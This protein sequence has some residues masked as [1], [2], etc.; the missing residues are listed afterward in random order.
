MFFWLI[1]AAMTLIA[2]VA[3][4]LPFTRRD[5]AGF[6]PT[7]A[8]DLQ[9]YRDQ[10]AEVERDLARGIIEPAE[11]GRLRNEI[12]RKVLDTDRALGRQLKAAAPAGG[13]GLGAV[14]LLGLCVL[15]GIMLYT[16]IGA[17]GMP[18]MGLATRIASADAHYAARPSQA[19][20]EATAKAGP[21]APTPP[22]DAQ[23][24]ELMERLRDAVAAN[25]DDVQGLAL[26]ANFEA[27]L[28]NTTAAQ[29]AQAHLIEVLGDQATADEHA[30]L[31]G[32]MAETAGGIITPE[33]E[34]QIDRALALDP[35]NIQA[36]YMSGLLHAQNGRPDLTFPIWHALLSDAPADS[37]WAASVRQSIEGIAWLAG[38][39]DYVPP[40]PRGAM[41]AP[42]LRAPDAD[43]MAAAAEMSDED[44][45]AFIAAMVEQLEHRLASEGGTPQEWAQLISAL[46]VIGKSEHARNILAE[47]RTVFARDD[48]ALALIESAAAHAGI[49]Q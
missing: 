4:V 39:P 14:L 23:M 27:R 33:G 46:G 24:A 37:P 31:A 47:A 19:E 13:R 41:T 11:A 21:A 30:R 20:A 48:A 34:A 10:L 42:I 25:P 17:P 9:V 22:V 18:D 12:G 35:R 28:G 45:A 2:A 15:G 26:L 38:N 8:Y 29:T 36:R 44:R 49:A 32:L 5:G 3:I 43:Q 6:Q 7:A 40:A 16:R 1:A